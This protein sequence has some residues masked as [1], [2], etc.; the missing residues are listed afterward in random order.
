MHYRIFVDGVTPSSDPKEA[1]AALRSVREAI[2]A[3][4]ARERGAGG[5]LQGRH[6]W[7]HDEHLAA[8]SE[9]RRDC[10]QDLRVASCMSV[11][12]ERLEALLSA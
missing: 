5:E 8:S 4:V 7:H 10:A 6:L 2:L 1:R 11:R 3:S 9:L 12:L